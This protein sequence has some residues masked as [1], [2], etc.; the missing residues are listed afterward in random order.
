[1]KN[2][3]KLIFWHIY[4]NI[5]ISPSKK[6]LLLDGWDNRAVL[7][8]DVVKCLKSPSKWN[9]KESSE[10]ETNCFRVYDR[11]RKMERWNFKYFCRPGI[12]YSYIKIGCNNFSKTE[13]DQ[14]RKFLIK[15]GLYK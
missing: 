3:K 7:L 1:M 9:M 12:M 5:R 10:D 13:V 4:K 14:L 15:M 2:D 11:G 8:S 6:Y